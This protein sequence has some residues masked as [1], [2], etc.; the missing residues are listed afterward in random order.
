MCIVA[1]LVSLRFMEKEIH[2]NSKYVPF[3]V[4]TSPEGS[5]R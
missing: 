4:W 5:L 1:D 3:F 2:A